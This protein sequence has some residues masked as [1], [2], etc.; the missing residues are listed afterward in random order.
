MIS[1]AALFGLSV[2]QIMDDFLIAVWEWERLDIVKRNVKRYI[3]LN[4][5]VI[6]KSCFMIR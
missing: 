1:E 6:E 3:T 4:L 5:K 2:V